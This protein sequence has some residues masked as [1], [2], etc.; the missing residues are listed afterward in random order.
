MEKHCGK[1]SAA[2]ASAESMSGS[3]PPS[4]GCF[5]LWFRH[6]IQ[7]NYGWF[8]FIQLLSIPDDIPY[9]SIPLTTLSL[10]QMQ[11]IPSGLRSGSR[12][13]L[14]RC[15][16][17]TICRS[18]HDGVKPHSCSTSITPATTGVPQ[19]CLLVYKPC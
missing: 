2:P 5:F 3:S 12:K 8:M 9:I 10:E 16:K 6:Q 4:G 17:P 13:R 11:H 14:H 1:P 19:L 7:G 15:G 18:F